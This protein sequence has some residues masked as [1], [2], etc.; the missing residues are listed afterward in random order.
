MSNKRIPRRVEING[1]WYD[2]REGWAGA[3]ELTAWGS[4]AKYTAKEP[5]MHVDNLYWVYDSGGSKVGEFHTTN[6]DKSGCVTDFQ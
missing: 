3:F 1:Q 4:S 5:Y 2:V 6:G